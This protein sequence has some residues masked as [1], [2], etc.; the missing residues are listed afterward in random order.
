MR[1]LVQL[2]PHFAKSTQQELLIDRC[3]VTDCMNAESGQLV[4]R[5]FADTIKA[6]GRQRP[7]SLRDIFQLQRR[8]AHRFL[9][10]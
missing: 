9:H 10:F 7:E 2:M 3:Q 8:D 6:A 4:S 1:V 5:I